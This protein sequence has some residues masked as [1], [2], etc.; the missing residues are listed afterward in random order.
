LFTSASV[1]LWLR[2]A[3]VYLHCAIIVNVVGST[4]SFNFRMR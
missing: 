4:A 1:A 2:L 3:T